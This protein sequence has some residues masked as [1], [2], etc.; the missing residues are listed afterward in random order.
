MAGSSNWTCP[1]CKMT[2]R[3]RL[4]R[5]PLCGICLEQSNDF[6]WVSLG[7]VALLAAGVF[8]LLSMTGWAATK[9]LWMHRR[10]E[11][12]TVW[13][14]QLFG[15]ITASILT[16]TATVI[17]FEERFSEGAWLYLVLIPI[18]YSSMSVVRSTR[19]M[20][21]TLEDNLGRAI[22]CICPGVKPIVCSCRRCRS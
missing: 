7:Q 8:V 3:K 6:L 22:G 14:P 15:V 16:S 10:A 18:L 11:G 4:L 20:P 17:I 1:F 5:V 2:T 21:S 13:S 12:L 19:G 9:R